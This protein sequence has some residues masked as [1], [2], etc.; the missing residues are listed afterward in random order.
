M[1]IARA[2]ARGNPL[3]P[4]N[5]SNDKG[6]LTVAMLPQNDDEVMK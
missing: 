6:I 4:A 2:S 5:G 1:V 3:L